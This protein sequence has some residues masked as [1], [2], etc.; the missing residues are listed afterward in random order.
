MRTTSESIDDKGQVTNL[1]TTDTRT[2][3]MGAD[4]AAYT[5][6]SEITVTIAGRRIA[7]TPQVVKHGYYGEPAGRPLVIKQLGEAPVTIDGKSIPCE[8]RQVAVDVEGGKLTSTLHYTSVVAPF[9]LR[10][11]SSLEGV[12]EEKRN[13]T[14]VEVIALDLPQRIKGDIKPSMYVKTTQKLPQGKKITLEVQCDDVPGGVVAHWASETDAAG[15]VLRRSTLELVDYGLPIVMGEPV[16]LM[17]RR[18]HRAAVKAARRMDG[19]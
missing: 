19:R 1:S 12:P 11:E 8:V 5:L 17:P 18:A 15:R 3:L 10:R 6:R 13:A 7:M 16:Q 2:T 4:D 14:L 9:V